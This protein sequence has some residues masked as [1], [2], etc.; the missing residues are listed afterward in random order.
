MSAVSIMSFTPTGMPSIA[1]SGLFARQ[2]SAA[3]AAAARAAV[4]PITVKAPTSVSR[5]SISARHSSSTCI[6][7]S[8]PL[9][10]PSSASGHKGEV[11]AAGS[12]NKLIAK[13]PGRSSPPSGWCSRAHRC[14][15][16]AGMTLR[17]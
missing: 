6:G 17:G 9:A 12:S 4:A 14:D 1:D 13:S 10:K 16:T 11:A 3:A 8:A 15:P 5:R 7:K 2:R